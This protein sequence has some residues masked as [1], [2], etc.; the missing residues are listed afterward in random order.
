MYKQKEKT[1]MRNVILFCLLL[2]T[3]CKTISAIRIISADDTICEYESL[4]GTSEYSDDMQQINQILAGIEDGFD[5]VKLYV[6]L[7]INSGCHFSELEV[8]VVVSDETED[9]VLL[10]LRDDIQNNIERLIEI[11]LLI[12]SDLDLLPWQVRFRLA[13]VK[14]PVVNQLSGEINRRVNFQAETDLRLKLLQIATELNISIAH[15]NINENNIQVQ[16]AD[17]TLNGDRI[18]RSERS[19]FTL[20]ARARLRRVV[21]TV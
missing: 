3:F 6:G 9:Q 15:I 2:A 8:I 17:R 12:I 10:D 11:K 1:I 19:R 20:M 18:S 21:R 16:L 4:Y 14:I 5:N 7:P 13:D